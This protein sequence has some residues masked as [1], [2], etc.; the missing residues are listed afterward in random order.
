VASRIAG[1]LRANANGVAGVRPLGPRR[2]H[3]EPAVCAR[4]P[5]P[6]SETPDRTLGYFAVIALMSMMMP[7]LSGNPS[8][9]AAAC[10]VAKKMLLRAGERWPGTSGV[11]TRVVLPGVHWG[12]LLLQGVVSFSNPGWWRRQLQLV[13][14]PAIVPCSA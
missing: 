13:K 3:D 11:A 12:R 14:I 1:T 10:A 8:L 5:P 7:H 2:H 9:S 4:G 6:V